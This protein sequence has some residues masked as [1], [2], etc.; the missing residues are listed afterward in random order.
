M[1][2]RAGIVRW[3]G[4]GVAVFAGTRVP[5]RNLMDCL[6]RGETIDAFV[7]AFPAV[8]RGQVVALLVAAHQA[9]VCGAEE[10]P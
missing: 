9:L 1:S 5:V 3:D 8:A 6:I 10:E 4:D 2:A 7:A